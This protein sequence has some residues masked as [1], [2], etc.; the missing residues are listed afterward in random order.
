MPRRPRTVRGT[1]GESQWDS[2]HT[3]VPGWLAQPLVTWMQPTFIAGQRDYMGNLVF[4]RQALMELQVELHRPLDWSVDDEW[5]YKSMISLM[6]ADHDFFVNVIDWCAGR[7]NDSRRLAELNAILTNGASAYK[8]GLDQDERGELQ[9]R[10]APTA[11]RAVQQAAAPGTAAERHLRG[12]WS[13]IY[14]RSKNPGHGYR[15]AI[16]AIECVASPVVIP[17]DPSPTLGKV[18][19]ALKAKPEKWTSVF[20][21]PA[22]VDPIQAVISDLELLWKSQDDRHG[23]PGSTAP[24]TVTQSEAE[25]A[26]HL[27]AALVH[28]FDSKAVRPV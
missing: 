14:G 27:A 16:K 12:A 3:G 9:D 13:S 25:A 6:S 22:G 7:C 19:S 10:I 17:A 8:V 1:G 23:I 24:I 18:I 5:A 11:E 4:Q 20:T 15:E 28:L 26:V 2:L 21:P